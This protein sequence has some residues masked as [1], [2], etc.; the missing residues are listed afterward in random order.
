GRRDLAI[1]QMRAILVEDPN[2][3][4][5][6]RSLTD[7]YWENGAG[8]EY[9]EA[10]NRFL[11]LAP[12][13]P[14]GFGNRGAA[15]LRTGDREGAKADFRRAM[16]LAP[17]Y[18][19]AA[20]SLFDEQLADKE[21]AAASGTLQVLREHNDDVYTRAREVQLLARTG[22]QAAALE[23]FR[24]LTVSSQDAAGPLQTAADAL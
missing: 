15:K 12:D 8:A 19:F 17:D 16:E 23:C 11:E 6:W 20:R 9:L 24:K 13:N 21:Y 4:W 3:F 2:Y 22:K 5:G 14:A 18:G 7:W 1:Q 10:A